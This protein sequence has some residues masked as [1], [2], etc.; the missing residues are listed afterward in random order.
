MR[1][2]AFPIVAAALLVLLLIFMY[3]G[4]GIA[5]PGT[6]WFRDNPGIMHAGNPDTIVF[7]GYPARTYSLDSNDVITVYGSFYASGSS[8]MCDRLGGYIKTSGAN[9]GSCLFADE[10]AIISKIDYIIDGRGN[11][12]DSFGVEG[13]NLI[14]YE[15]YGYVPSGMTWYMT[16]GVSAPEPP[17]VEPPVEPP[18]EPPV[19]PPQ[20]YFDLL[21]SFITDIINS[22]RE[23]FS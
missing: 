2:G 16:T 17:P 13:S 12:Y 7:T 19:E 4:T 18:I 9:V 11:R 8:E 6:I 3:Y 5:V 14:I 22:I 20:T 21:I 15:N 1:K 23:M 10:T